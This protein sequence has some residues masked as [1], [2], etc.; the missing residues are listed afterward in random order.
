MKILRLVRHNS[1]LFAAVAF[2][3]FM[4]TPVASP[5]H[6]W[7]NLHST[8]PSQTYL[9]QT[10]AKH[11]EVSPKYH[12]LWAT[13]ASDHPVLAFPVANSPWKMI[14]QYRTYFFVFTFLALS[15]WL[16]HSAP[17]SFGLRIWKRVDIWTG[18]HVSKT[19]TGNLRWIHGT[20]FDC[21]STM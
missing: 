12:V 15:A 10:A 2:T 4:S 7:Q 3:H 21:Y 18:F 8:R 6:K 13:G 1:S 5:V 11:E 16:F 14:Q 17:T 9:L 19:H 20:G